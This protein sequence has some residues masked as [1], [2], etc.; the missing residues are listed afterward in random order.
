M[1]HIKVNIETPGEMVIE[2]TLIP[3]EYAVSDVIAELVDEMELPR[4]SEEGLPITYSLYHVN[5]RNT[6]RPEQLLSE[7]EVRGGDTIRL[8]SSH[9]VQAVSAGRFEK[10]VGREGE[11]DKSNGESLEVVLSVL[12]LNKSERVGLPYDRK[13]GEVIRMIVADYS[14]PVRDKLNERITYR[15]VSKAIGRYLMDSE[16][17]GQAG[18]PRLDRLS[19][20]R[21]EV[22]GA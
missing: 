14:L 7:T 3:Q 21:E 22:A 18:I 1:A 5:G 9:D 17:L 8:V 12:D 6:L 16:T 13:V 10:E 4:L 20:H 2:D 19:L 11:Q 15:L